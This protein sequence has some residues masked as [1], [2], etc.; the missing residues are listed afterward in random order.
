[1]SAAEPSLAP[2]VRDLYR[3]LPEMHRL[4]PWELQHVLFSLGYT[5]ELADEAEITAALVVV[6]FELAARRPAA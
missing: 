4:A 2:A 6:R 3:R 1:V 5:D